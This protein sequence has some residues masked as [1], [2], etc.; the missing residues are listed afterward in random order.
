MTI[1][2][3]IAKSLSLDDF[4]NREMRQFRA[5]TLREVGDLHQRQVH[6]HQASIDE[7]PE[8][9]RHLPTLR[10]NQ[11]AVTTQLAALTTE[12]KTF[13]EE[14]GSDR[15]RRMWIAAEAAQ[16]HS[17]ASLAA[18]EKDDLKLAAAEQQHAVESL[19]TLLA[20]SKNH[21]FAAILG[22]LTIGVI[23]AWHAAPK[24]IRVIPAP[25]IAVVGAAALAAALSLPVL[26]V[27][28][29]S[30][31]WEEVRF[32]TWSVFTTVPWQTLLKHTLVIAVVASAE[33]LLCAAAVDQMQ[34]GPRTRYDRELCA[35]G[36]GNLVCGCLGALPMT[37]VIVRSSAN[38]NAGAKTRLSAFL[39]G[40]WLLVFVAALGFLLQL[41]PTASLAAILVFTGY[42]LVDIKSI[43]ELRKYGWGEVA[44]YA[45][46][47]VTIVA[48]DLLTGVL[49]GV[50][51]AAGK[52]LYTFSHLKIGLQS[53][54]DTNT[55]VLRLQGTATFLRLPLLARYL[56]KVPRGATLHV[57]FEQ[58]KYID[59]A[60]LD[61]LMTW[62]RQHEA[63]GGDL[64]IDWD[65]LHASFRGGI[66]E[67]KSSHEQNTADK[68]AA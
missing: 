45:A 51:L 5:D 34:N 46:T 3:A 41:I 49:V 1:P 53:R 31:L 12:L 42:K 21:S 56:E 15:A 23:V 35:Q 20:R 57:D 11:Q 50:A 19:E 43:R 28:T 37:G 22:L 33:T 52:L 38:I 32:P 62:G 10:N 2:K 63:T 24:S 25:L 67:V 13:H 59:H 18:L 8:V 26:Y 39:H 4:H 61:L 9:P 47:V 54:L 14:S 64:V 65:T 58:L 16:H 29:P 27:E 6:L 7:N 68:N 17:E 66:S 30:S 60:C 40:V 44:I 36:I 55:A 48:V